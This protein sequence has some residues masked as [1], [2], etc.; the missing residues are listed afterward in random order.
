MSSPR[1]KSG[2]TPP[3]LV[4]ARPRMTDVLS[5]MATQEQLE[6]ITCIQWASRARHMYMRHRKLWE[7]AYILQALE[8]AGCLVPGKR[9][10]GFGVGREPLSAVMASRGCEV[11]ATDLGSEAAKGQAWIASNQHASALEDLND[12]GICDRDRFRRLVTFRPTDM[13][14]IPEDLTGFDFLWSSCAMEHLGSIEAGM[15]FVRNSMRCLKP[16]GIAVHTT[17]YNLQSNRATLTQGT[18]VIF[19]RRD[20][21]DLAGGL[22]A[23]GHEIVLNFTPGDGELD[24][25]VDRPP[26]SDAR[27]LVLLVGDCVVTSFGLVIR[28]QGGDTAYSPLRVAERA[29]GRA[30]RRIEGLPGAVRRWLRSFAGAFPSGRR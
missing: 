26:Y 13:N 28:K 24:R 20:L 6:S 14:D 19:R 2:W 21:E 10:L 18:V 15:Q 22:L 29:R 3:I 16:G 1:A 25:T 17:E 8:E 5:Q 23:D 11:V 7:F 9:G 12:R 30:W 27:H 4:K